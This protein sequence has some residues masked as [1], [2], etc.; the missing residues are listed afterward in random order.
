M[1]SGHSTK[2]ATMPLVLPVPADRAPPP[3]DLEIRPKQVRAWIDSLPLAHAVD[4]GRKILAHLTALNRSRVDTD[5]RLQILEGYRPIARTMIEE[6]EAIYGKASLPLAPRPREALDLARAL[7]GELALGYK[8]VLAEKSGKLIAFGARKQVPLLLLRV[9][10]YQVARLMAG[11]KSYTSTPAGAWAEIH[12]LFL[13]AEKDG[14]V[15]EA[16][17]PETK[18]SIAE[19][20]CE[21]LLLSLTDPYRLS[22][23]EADKVLAQIRGARAGVTLSQSRPQT[24]PGGHFI[25]PCDTDK[26]PKPALSASDDTGGPNWRLFDANPLVDK[27]RARKQAMETGNVSSTMTKAMGPDGTNLLAKLITLWGD[28]PK[29]SSRRDA[30]EDTSVAI[31][32]GL[33]A[34]AHFVA[35]EGEAKEI[36]A[37]AIR[38]GNTVPLLAVPDDEV[39][40][41]MNVLEWDVINMSD[42]G[43]K[44]RRASPTQQPLAIGEVVGLRLLGRAHWAV[45]V[46]RWIT[47]LDEGGL[48]CGVQFLANAARYVEVAPTI[49]A[50][51]PQPKPALALLDDHSDESDT[52]LAQSGT[53]SDLREFH[54][55]DRGQVSVVRARGLIE[56]TARFDLFHVSPS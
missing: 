4:A 3:K 23:G 17:D 11:Y 5:D 38:D 53:F 24:R 47:A 46:V 26:P 43:V 15:A 37:R 49:A 41:S 56:K 12:Q 27:L 52:L 39:S 45:G 14:V 51:M 13:Q 2:N 19:L 36:E 31:A 10:Q 32:V 50:G 1:L 28:P 54:I 20:Y 8:V 9:M 7:A 48:E 42:G 30:M 55:E 44:V 21:T 22:P 40:R 16:A 18:G 29:R 25:V 35:L 33:K 34:A 6:M